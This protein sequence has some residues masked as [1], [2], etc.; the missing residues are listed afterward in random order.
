MMTKK[1]VIE[2]TGTL[3]SSAIDNRVVFEAHPPHIVFETGKAK[4]TY[5]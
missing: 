4:E 3:A 2:R 1:K 5:T